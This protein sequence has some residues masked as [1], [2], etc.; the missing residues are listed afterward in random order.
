MSLFCIA[1]GHKL[2]LWEVKVTREL[3]EGL[4]EYPAISGKCPD[5]RKEYHFEKI[6]EGVYDIKLRSKDELHVIVDS[7]FWENVAMTDEDM[8]KEYEPEDAHEP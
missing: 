5:C 3:E 1:C 6:R 8:E 2:N 7:D 4:L